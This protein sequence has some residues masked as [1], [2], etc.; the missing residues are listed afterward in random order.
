[1][2][3]GAIGHTD[4]SHDPLFP[5]A[6]KEADRLNR[7]VTNADIARQQVPLT[8]TC[9]VPL[10]LKTFGGRGGGG[11]PSPPVLLRANYS[12]NTVANGGK[13]NNV[14]GHGVV[15]LE[16]MP[17]GVQLPPF[18]ISQADERASDAIHGISPLKRQNE[19]LKA[20]S[21]SPP[22]MNFCFFLHRGFHRNGF[23]TAAHPWRMPLISSRP[24]S[25]SLHVCAVQTETT[26]NITPGR[27]VNPTL[28]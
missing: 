17:N 5:Q 25:F 20:V 3:T 27:N 2:P 19:E 15:S 24:M 6:Y 16:W 9:V 22:F 21:P 26:S 7:H 18:S 11:N 14:R 12:W 4:H 8:C 10:Q 23:L 28:N 1:M 13:Y